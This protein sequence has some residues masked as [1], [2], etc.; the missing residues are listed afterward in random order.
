MNKDSYIRVSYGKI[1]VVT[2][3][4]V[5][6]LYVGDVYRVRID[7]G[8]YFD[9]ILKELLLP[10]VSGLLPAISVKLIT[11]TM[12]KIT[13]ALCI[14]HEKLASEEERR[15]AASIGLDPAKFGIYEMPVIWLIRHEY[16]IL[17][18]GNP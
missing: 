4:G 16:S 6:I 3:V 14:Y 11:P 8:H 15:A 1:E 18:H 7:D 12:G 9:M 2:T 10:K 5:N 17:H 13:S